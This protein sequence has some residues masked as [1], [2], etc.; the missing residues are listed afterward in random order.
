MI[1]ELLEADLV[2]AAL[3]DLIHCPQR[4]L[5]ADRRLV[6][7]PDQRPTLQPPRGPVRRSGRSVRR[8]AIR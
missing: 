2:T 6:A 3:A 1:N 5:A 4:L 8:G 7:A